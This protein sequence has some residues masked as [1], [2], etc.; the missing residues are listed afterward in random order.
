VTA[1][2]FW[3][4]VAAV[5]ITA[6][7]AIE[8]ALSLFLP[9]QFSTAGTILVYASTAVLVAVVWAVCF[10]S[11]VQRLRISLTAILAL[12]AMEAIWFAAIRIFDPFWSVA[13]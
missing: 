3:L 8:A 7:C 2:T 1:K 10:R 4:T 13:H 9:W 6:G 5:V 12:V 11:Q